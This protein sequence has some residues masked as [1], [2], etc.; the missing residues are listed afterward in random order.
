MDA[1]ARPRDPARALAR[2]STRSP[3]RPR[4]RAGAAKRLAIK[5]RDNLGA[6]GINLLNSCEAAAWQTVFHFHIHVIPRY[7]DDP[8]RL[9]VPPRSRRRTSWRKVAE[10]AAWLA[11][12]SSSDGD[13]GVM[14]ID[15]AA[16]EP[17]RRGA[18]EGAH[19]R[20]GRGRGRRAARA[21]DP[22]RGQ[23]LHRRGRRR[24]VQGPT[25]NEDGGA[26][27]RAWSQIVHKLEAMP[28]PDARVGARA[29]PDRR[30]SSSRWPA[31]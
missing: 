11:S 21:G 12:G 1:R 23:G 14:V 25:P 28:V 18:D 26:V 8:L 27:P 3:T 7:E 6:D 4:P 13:V 31:T 9:P 24:R 10:R 30:A 2:T 15:V 17:V 16:A 20:A 22:R 29:V 19:G 5:M